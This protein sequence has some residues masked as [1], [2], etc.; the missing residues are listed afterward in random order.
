MNHRPA[1]VLAGQRNDGRLQH[2]S[3]SQW[4]AEIPLQGRMMV[5]YVVDALRQSGRV[6]PIIVVGP[7]SL[8]LHDVIWAPVHDEM[9]A[10]VL[11]GLEMAGEGAA[12][13]ATADMPLLNSAIVNAFLDEADAQYDV[14]YPIIEK[15]V[16][17]AKFPET[18]RTYVR[19]KDGIF[20]GGNLLMVRK[21]AVIRSQEAVTELLSHRKSPWKLARD[22]GWL[23]LLKWMV[24]RLSIDDAR[25]R[26][27]QLLGIDGQALIFEYPEVG[28]DVD[29]PEDWALAERLLQQK[30]E[31]STQST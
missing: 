10:N 23:M 24:G 9:F 22:I 30:V 16:V 14:V 17:E 11:S 27:R 18:Q 31:S 8:G 6:S 25:S 13:V 15:S 28:V 29:K 20:T 5:E 12:L 19:L 3:Q 21:E 1:I 2:V 26:V 7:K 4:E